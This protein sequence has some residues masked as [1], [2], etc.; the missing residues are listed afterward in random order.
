MDVP[1]HDQA[2]DPE[3]V[4]LSPQWRTKRA[5]ASWPDIRYSG[6]AILA[7]A[8]TCGCEAVYSEDTSNGQ[9]YGGPNVIAPFPT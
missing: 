2:Y 1:A 8:R 9:D 6:S 4:R 3:F 5:P 7:A